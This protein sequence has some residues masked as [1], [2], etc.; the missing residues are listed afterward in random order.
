MTYMLINSVKELAD[1]NDQVSKTLMELQA[2]NARLIEE[3]E[4]LRKK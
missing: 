3:I 1:K 4:R 2:I